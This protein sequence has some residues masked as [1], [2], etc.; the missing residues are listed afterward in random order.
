MYTIIRFCIKKKTWNHLNSYKNTQIFYIFQR[1]RKQRFDL[2][3]VVFSS[4]GTWALGR[5]AWSRLEGNGSTCTPLWINTRLHLWSLSYTF[6]SFQPMKNKGMT[7][8]E[9]HKTRTSELHPQRVAK[10][11]TPKLYVFCVYV[12]NC[13][14]KVFSKVVVIY[15]LKDDLPMYLWSIHGFLAAK[16]GGAFERRR[17]LGG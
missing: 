17:T 10:L 15:L 11:W 3:E 6:V 12:K 16:V 8:D 9:N 14:V 1:R 2:S 4:D 13:T 5:H 7:C